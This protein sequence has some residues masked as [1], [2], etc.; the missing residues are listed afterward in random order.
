MEI[1]EIVKVHCIITSFENINPLSTTDLVTPFLIGSY[2]EMFL[3]VANYDT[4]FKMLHHKLANE[5]T[6]T[7]TLSDL[8]NT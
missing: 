7:N 5:T 2:H 3:F 1:G 4:G 6:F 8:F